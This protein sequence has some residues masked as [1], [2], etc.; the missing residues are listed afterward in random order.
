LPDGHPDLEGVWENNV[1]TPLERPREL[2]A[3]PMLS[4]AEVETLKRRA[5]ERF[6][7][8][9]DATFG[10]SLYLSLLGETGLF[11]AEATGNYSQNW[12]PDRYFERRTSLITDP[13]DGRLPAMTEEGIARQR[14]LA[15]TRAR[16]PARAQDLSLPNRCVS[17]GVPD[18]FAAYMSVYRIV[19]GPDSVVIAME[20]MHD[21]R[22]IPMDGRPHVASP[23]RQYMGDSRGHWDGDTL[24]VETTN[25]SPNGN[26]MGGI[27]NRSSERLTLTERFRR[28]SA[29]TLEYTFTVDDP[30]VWTRPWTAMIPWKR[31]TGEVLEY[32]CHEGNY[33]LRG[34]LS[35]ARAAEA[36]G[37]R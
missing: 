35:A 23:I 20:K 7:P 27:F 26:P 25:F 4:E 6:T 8:D 14:A 32:A 5:R 13:Q 24:V 16:P 3:K 34:M 15:A 22:V 37:S 12:L 11:G 21:A 2:A 30:G 29:D 31:S 1:A 19:Q 18:L 9:V 28:V 10:D 17:F 36:G 33:S